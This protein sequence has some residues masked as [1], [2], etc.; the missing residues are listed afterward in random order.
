MAVTTKKTF[1]AVGSGGQSSTTVF[2]PVSIELN[3][4]DDLDVYVTL[5]GGTRVLQYRQSTGGTTDSNHPQVNDTT[6]LY[7]PAQN[8]GVTLQNYTL[9]T[10]NNTITFN[11]ALP[12]GAVVSI[13]RRTRDSSSDYTNF[14]GG[15]T[16]R[17]TDVNAAFDESNFTAQE[18]RNKAFELEGI[19]FDGEAKDTLD[20][21]G[22]DLD[23]NEK[24]RL[25]TGNDAEIYHGG[26]NTRFKNDTGDLI[27]ACGSDDIR[28]AAK[29]DI[30][31]EVNAT[32]SDAG[33]TE[34]G[35]IVH[36]NAAVN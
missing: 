11:S 28:L 32:D 15:S 6:G 34:N 14:A 25:G 18:A 35:I 2:T 21:D 13:E 10:D 29:D 30:Y 36:G 19:L 4:Q 5:S 23:D 26:A 16:I 1:N 27:I 17:H 8:T 3:N 7:F 31:L 24:I 22:I 9:S 20:I 12:T 33:T